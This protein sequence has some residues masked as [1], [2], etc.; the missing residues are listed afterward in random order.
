MLQ[1]LFYFPQIHL[2][3]GYDMGMSVEF[4]PDT[5][6]QFRLLNYLNFMI[7]EEKEAHAS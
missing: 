3:N 2:T 6:T 7:F 5:R 4:I 1:G